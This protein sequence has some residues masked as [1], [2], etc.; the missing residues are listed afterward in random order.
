MELWKAVVGVVWVWI[1]LLRKRPRDAELRRLRVT[2]AQ[3]WESSVET[4]TLDLGKE[5]DS[6]RGTVG[7]DNRGLD[8]DGGN[9]TDGR[10]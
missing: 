7:G 8:T 3:R 6:G 10:R 9:H 5:D 1:F 4:G 2:A